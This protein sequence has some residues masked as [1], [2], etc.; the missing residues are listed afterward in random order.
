MRSAGRAASG[1]SHPGM[2]EAEQ[3]LL[4]K[5]VGQPVSVGVGSHLHAG[6]CQ[7]SVAPATGPNELVSS[8]ACKQ[9]FEQGVST[10]RTVSNSDSMTANFP[11]RW[12]HKA[13]FAL[14]L[15]SSRMRDGSTRRGLLPESATDQHPAPKRAQ[16]GK[17]SPETR[18][19]SP[20]FSIELARHADELGH[21]LT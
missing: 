17:I 14:G 15:G 18:S 5:G 6:V 21:F 11:A 2:H 20:K 16:S 7:S 3:V 9:P 19:L 13:G 10:L 8:R 1:W 4:G 12:K